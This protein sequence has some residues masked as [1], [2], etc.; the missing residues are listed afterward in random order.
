V[1]VSSGVQDE[2]VTDRQQKYTTARNQRL[3]ASSER[4]T[5]RDVVLDA[6]L[7][8]VPENYDDIP[9]GLN[10]RSVGDFVVAPVPP[11]TEWVYL[12]RPHGDH[13]V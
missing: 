5:S 13:S 2:A 4:F 1:G 6:G 7:E 12:D 9:R 3:Q 11:D 8:D 10:E